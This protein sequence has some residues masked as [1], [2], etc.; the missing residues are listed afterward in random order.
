MKAQEL[1]CI[2][3]PIGCHMSV[4]K[5]GEDY[6]V[7]GNGCPRGIAYTKKEL[8]APSRTLTTTVKISHSNFRRLPVKTSS[9]VPK[10][11]LFDVMEEINTLTVEA[12]IKMGDIIL[13]D[14]LGLGV[15]I[16]SSKNMPRV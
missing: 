13:K 8:T 14:V 15:D 16:V 9:E 10:E 12:P 2:V 5:K 6:T 4:E 11:R 3:C 7:T 1:I